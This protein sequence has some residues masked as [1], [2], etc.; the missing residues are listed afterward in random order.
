MI[1]MNSKFG[2]S[3]PVKLPRNFL[4]NS[5]SKVD[6]FCK[7]FNR[8]LFARFVGTS[9]SRSNVVKLPLLVEQREKTVLFFQDDLWQDEELFP[10]SIFIHFRF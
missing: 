7:S 1:I 8:K 3:G 10:N 6:F 4:L 2:V 5:L 9:F